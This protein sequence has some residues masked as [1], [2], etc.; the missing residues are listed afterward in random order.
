MSHT[1]H[2]TH[3][4]RHLHMCSVMHTMGPRENVRRMRPSAADIRLGVRG[5]YYG[6]A[7]VMLGVWSETVRGL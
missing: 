3:I 7:V 2:V 6:F 1:S 4:T 5:K